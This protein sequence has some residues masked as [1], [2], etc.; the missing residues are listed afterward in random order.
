MMKWW[1]LP[2]LP[3]YIPSHLSARNSFLGF[4]LLFLLSKARSNAGDTL[5]KEAM[6]L[7]IDYN[8]Y[9]YYYFIF[10]CDEKLILCVI[11]LK[12]WLFQLFCIREIIVKYWDLRE[13]K[14]R[15]KSSLFFVCIQRTSNMAI[16]WQL[17][18]MPIISDL[19]LGE[20]ASYYRRKWYWLACERTFCW[21]SS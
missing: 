8:Y 18:T 3:L 5:R 1:E 13:R 7:C 19:T 16:Y 20:W 11:V 6:F 2:V 17:F 14:R 9:P 10:T 15:E 4:C 21:T 12:Q